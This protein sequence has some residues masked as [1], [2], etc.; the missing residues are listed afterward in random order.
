MQKYYLHI[1]I[2][3]M[4]LTANSKEKIFWFQVRSIET[5]VLLVTLKYIEVVWYLCPDRGLSIIL[6]AC[7]EFLDIIDNF[8]LAVWVVRPVF[9]LQGCH[10]L[11]YFGLF[12]FGTSGLQSCSISEIIEASRMH[13]TTIS[14]TIATLF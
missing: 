10:F 2:L 12:Q 1:L 8:W 5:T 9:Y 6:L 13:L 3:V 4:S 11:F 14:S 7:R